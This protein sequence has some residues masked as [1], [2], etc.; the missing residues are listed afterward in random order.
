MGGRNVLRPELLNAAGQLR[1]LLHLRE[2]AGLCDHLVTYVAPTMLGRDG[3]PALDLDGPARI[4]D[5]ARWRLVD[6]TR[7][8]TDVR[9]DYE[10]PAPLDGGN[11]AGHWVFG[12]SSRAVRDV[13]VAGEVVVRERRLTRVDQGELSRNAAR[14]AKR[15][16]DRLQEI[17]PHPFE[18]KQ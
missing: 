18:P 3:R 13:L 1:R 8:G 4:A 14:D 15:L 10:P 11:I 17:G 6:V 16:W 7:V 2:M 9:L 5:A 12:L